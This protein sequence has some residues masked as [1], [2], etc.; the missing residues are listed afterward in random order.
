M[1]KNKQI[2]IYKNLFN[3]YREKSYFKWQKKNIEKI[4]A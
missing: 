3:L 1:K 4:I 2:E